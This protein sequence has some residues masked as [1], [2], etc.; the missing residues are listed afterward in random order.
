MPRPCRCESPA[1]DAY[2]TLH[3]GDEGTYRVYRCQR[4]GGGYDSVRDSEPLPL[5]AP[6]ALWEC[7]R[8]RAPNPVG[9]RGCTNCPAHSEDWTCPAC[10]G[11][12]A[13]SD[14]CPQCGERRPGAPKII[15]LSG[16]L[17]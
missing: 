8:C 9:A 2:G 11:I 5:G 13:P 12:S 6:L 7:P 14:T 1:T 3:L 15:L 10:R 16:G 17:P 4:C